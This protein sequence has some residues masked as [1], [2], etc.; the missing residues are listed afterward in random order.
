M[1]RYFDK[2]GTASRISL[3]DTLIVKKEN[4]FKGKFYSLNKSEPYYTLITLGG[5]KY[6]TEPEIDLKKVNAELNN[7]YCLTSYIELSDKLDKE[8]PLHHYTFRNAFYAWEKEFNKTIN[9]N[10]FI[11]QTNEAIAK[12]SDSISKVH[13]A[14]TKT[15]NFITDNVKHANYTTLKDSI[16]ILPM[17]WRPQNGYFDKSV[18]QMSKTNPEYFYKLL[19]D[20]PAGKK[21]IYFAVDQ[22]KVLVKQLKNVKGYDEL[23]NEFLKEY[24]YGKTMPYR[25]LS[26][27][28][29]F[30]GLLTWLI[31]SQP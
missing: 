31:I 10:E 5:Q 16:S 24:N 1:G 14:L 9:H 28:L 25:A 4:E 2:A 26:L 22:D 20:F 29:V 13:G 19:R 27:I 7:A 18:Y 30:G 15:T 12:I 8:F 17:D 21:F 3:T 23:K 11:E 6:Q